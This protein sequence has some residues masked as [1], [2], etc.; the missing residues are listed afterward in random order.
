M[1]DRDA[2]FEGEYQQYLDD[3]EE[4]ERES[5]Q[6]KFGGGAPVYFVEDDTTPLTVIERRISEDIPVYRVRSTKGENDFWLTEY[7]LSDKPSK[8]HP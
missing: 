1:I 2:E 7:E 4:A 5:A 3:I 6:Y 8:E